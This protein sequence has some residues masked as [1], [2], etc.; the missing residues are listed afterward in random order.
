MIVGIDNGLDGGICA[1]SAFSGSLIG[2]MEMPCKERA[3]KRE[4]DTLEVY[5]WIMNLNTDSRILIE[6]PSNMRRHHKPCAQW[7]SHSANCSACASPISSQ[8]SLLKWLNGR[9]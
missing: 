8:L 7:A 5:K 6:E 1:I 9:M 4:I 3:G 2:Y